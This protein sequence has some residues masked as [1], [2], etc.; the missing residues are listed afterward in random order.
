[1]NGKVIIAFA[2]CLI[3]V[4]AGLIPLESAKY[5]EGP[6]TKTKI[7]G[8]DGSVIDA[9]APGGRILLEGN[10]GPVLQAAPV[11]YA[12]PGVAGFEYEQLVVPE[13]ASNAVE[14]AVP[15]ATTKLSAEGEETVFLHPGT[16]PR[17]E[18]RES[19]PVKEEVEEIEQT[20]SYTTELPATTEEVQTST[21][22]LSGTYVPDNLEKLY[23]DGS[24]RP[25][26][27]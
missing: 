22:D 11:V 20:T 15:V 5:L 18:T 17:V 16:E 12:Q 26:H 27:Y 4:N 8:P 24:Y 1:M 3:A 23:D 6:S 7:V 19:V 2:S 21:P 9:Y 13:S 10:A 14:V 25:E